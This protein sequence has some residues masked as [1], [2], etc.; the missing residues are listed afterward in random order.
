MES[1]YFL[2][3]GDRKLRYI[4]HSYFIQLNF[5]LANII[6]IYIFFFFKKK[7]FGVASEDKD[8]KDL[9]E[10]TLNEITLDG[11][12]GLRMLISDVLVDGKIIY[13]FIYLL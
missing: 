9:E 3:I 6:Y 12:P 1:K 10:C 8:L 5:H 13:L 4:L 2:F 7:K 11:V